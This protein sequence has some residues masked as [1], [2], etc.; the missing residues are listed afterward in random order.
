MQFLNRQPDPEHF[1]QLGRAKI[2]GR[3]LS[4]WAMHTIADDAVARFLNAPPPA[5][6]MNDHRARGFL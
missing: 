1:D 6:A 2:R 4:G 3:Y 5:F